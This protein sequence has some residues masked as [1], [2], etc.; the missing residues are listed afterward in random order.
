MFQKNILIILGFFFIVSCSSSPKKG[1]G[2]SD[3][4]ENIDSEISFGGVGPADDDPFFSDP[5][6]DDTF[7]AAQMDAKAEEPTETAVN[8]PAPSA[9]AEPAL[10]MPEEVEESEEPV[11]EITPVESVQRNKASVAVKDAMRSPA[12]NCNMRSDAVPG[13]A[14]VGMVKRGRKIWTE[15]HD[16][17]WFKVY[18]KQG[19]AF[20]SKTCF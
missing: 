19:H 14:K 6:S 13:S 7:D 17:G 4:P 16:S 8:I 9:E 20:V 1:D 12:N 5:D 15:N 3:N 18:R 2:K 11:A 10:D